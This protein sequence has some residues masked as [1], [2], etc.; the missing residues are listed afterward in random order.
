MQI[1][2]KNIIFVDYNNLFSLNKREK[3]T[4]YF[5]AKN[6]QITYKTMNIKNLALLLLVIFSFGC[7]NKQSAIINGHFHGHSK[8]RL[9]VEKILPGASS[10]VID[11]L[12]TDNEGYFSVEVNFE[13]QTPLFVNIRTIDSYVPLLV[14]PGENVKVSS[15]GNIYNNYEV[16]GSEGSQK[17][18]ELNSITTDRIKSL[19]SLSR[20]FSSTL[21]EERAAELSRDY[22]HEYIQLKRQVIRFVISNPH[23]LAA[24]VPLYQPMVNGRFIFDEP[25]DII[26]FRTIADSLAVTHPE[27]PYVI[28]LLRDVEESRNSF[29]MDSTVTA[30]LEDIVVSLPEIELK[31]AE[32][33]LRK[34]ST[35]VKK[36]KVTLLDFTKI[37]VP[38]LKVRNREIYEIYEK[39]KDQGFEVFQVSLD[40]SKPEWLNAVVDARLDWISVNDPRSNASPFLGIYNVQSLPSNFLI[41]SEANIVTKNI[42]SPEVLEKEILKI[43]NN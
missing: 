26:Y 11:T 34:L 39:Y 5:T 13:H 19:D 31:D 29:V 33:Q 4:H 15:I 1:Y 17:L 42:S 43:I 40:A 22:T 37:T 2:E 3:K 23:S 35:E 38:E 6:Q 12:S 25:T 18:R 14:S 10:R 27:S 20:L 7:S 36:A 16:K 24:I 21:S 32:G 41:D 8:E 28:S 30:N 9:A